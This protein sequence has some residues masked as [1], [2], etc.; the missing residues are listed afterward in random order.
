M[1][2]VWT[3][4]YVDAWSPGYVAAD[5]D[6]SQRADALL[7]DFWERGRDDDGAHDLGANPARG[8]RGRAHRRYDEAAWYRPNPPYKTVLWSMRDN[9]NYAETGVLSSLE[10]ASGFP[11]VI[12]QDFYVKTRRAGCR[13]RRMRRMGMCCRRIRRILTRVAFVIHIL[14]MQGIEVGRA[15]AAVKLTDGRISRRAR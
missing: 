8:R 6:E 12:L 5:G 9:T 1:P 13:R 4:G 10:F 15:K 7:R 3:H 2:G 14:R 11:Q